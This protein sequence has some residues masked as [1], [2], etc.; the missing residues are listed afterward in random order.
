MEL[1]SESLIRLVNVDE[2]LLSTIDS[3]NGEI[4]AVKYDDNKR[5]FVW[6]CSKENWELGVDMLKSLERFAAENERGGA[7]QFL[8]PDGSSD[9]QLYFDYSGAGFGHEEKA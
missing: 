8:P 5:V 4:A 3:G 6:R 2:V 7:H 9:V 1:S